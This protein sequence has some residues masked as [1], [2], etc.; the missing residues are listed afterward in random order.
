VDGYGLAF[1]N[2]GSPYE[3]KFYNADPGTDMAIGLAPNDAFTFSEGKLTITE[4]APEP[5]SWL[6]GAA[7]LAIAVGA[8]TRK[9]LASRKTA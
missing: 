2:V 7:V 5:A 4:A 9:F 1:H 8:R 6:G 3:Y